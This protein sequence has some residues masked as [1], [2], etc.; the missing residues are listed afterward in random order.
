MPRC[1]SLWAAGLAVPRCVS[2]CAG[3]LWH[4]S[5]LLFG[6]SLYPRWPWESALSLPT[7][8]YHRWSNHKMITPTTEEDWPCVVLGRLRSGKRPGTPSL[9]SSRSRE[10]PSPN[11]QMAEGTPWAHRA[12]KHGAAAGSA[13]RSWPRHHRCSYCRELQEPP[14]CTTGECTRKKKGKGKGKGRE[15]RSE[16]GGVDEGIKENRGNPRRATFGG[17]KIRKT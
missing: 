8:P 3:T 5:L 2:L 14:L 15:E 12:R 10:L 17:L 1:A 7:R 13:P 4:T 6:T 9:G 11:R 16:A